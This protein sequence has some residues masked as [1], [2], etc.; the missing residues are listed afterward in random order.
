MQLRNCRRESLA[1]EG[2]D[3][4]PSLFTFTVRYSLRCSP[5]GFLGIRRGTSAPISGQSDKFGLPDRGSKYPFGIGWVPT[6]NNQV[7]LNPS[8]DR[9]NG[10]LAWPAPRRCVNRKLPPNQRP[11]LWESSPFRAGRMSTLAYLQQHRRQILAQ[12]RRQT[13]RGQHRNRQQPR[14]DNQDLNFCQRSEGLRVLDRIFWSGKE[15]TT[16]ESQ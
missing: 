6:L 10:Y 16:S 8:R 11:T 2:G 3:E 15:T 13:Q 4:S 7:P 14:Q 9:S 12:L 1:R 5:C